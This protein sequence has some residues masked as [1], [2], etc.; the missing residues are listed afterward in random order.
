MVIL[1]AFGSLE[2]MC[3]LLLEKNQGW[4][5][6]WLAPQQVR[7]LVANDKTDLY[8]KR[9]YETLN[10]QGFR[11]AIESGKE[12]LKARL[13]RAIVEKVPYI[14]LLG[15]R[16]E[17]GEVLTI[18]TYGGSEEQTLSLDEFCIRLKREMGSGNSELKN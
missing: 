16:E 13:Y 7:I 2:R 1:S 14:L 6:F 15:E 11:V 9:V 12:P 4:L 18:R 10:T 5:P 3:A 8:A 17:R